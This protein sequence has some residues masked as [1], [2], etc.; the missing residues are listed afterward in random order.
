MLCTPVHSLRGSSESVDCL[1]WLEHSYVAVSTPVTPSFKTLYQLLMTSIAKD[2]V[3]VDSWIT[4]EKCVV[5]IAKF[6]E[7]CTATTIYK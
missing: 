6:D 5:S 7:F 3:G 4:H 1:T 2:E